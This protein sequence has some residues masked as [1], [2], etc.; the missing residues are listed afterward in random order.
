MLKQIVVIVQTAG[1]IR[2][3]EKIVPPSLA[4]AVACC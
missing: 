2:A 3:D 1:N 4:G